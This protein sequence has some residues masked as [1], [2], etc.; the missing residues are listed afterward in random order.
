M[1]DNLPTLE[2]YS[3]GL[4]TKLAMAA[5]LLKS[6]LIPTS[7]KSPE[8]VLVAIL[9]GQEVGLSPLQ[10]LQSVTVIQGR[11][12]LD[13][14]SLKAICIAH[15]MRFETVEWNEKICT[16]RGVRG[17]WKEEFSFTWHDAELMGLSNKENWRRMPKQM[18]YARAVSTL[19]RNMGADIVRGFYSKEEMQDSVPLDVTPKIEKVN[20]KEIQKIAEYTHGYSDEEI[21][22]FTKL[23]DEKTPEVSS[24]IKAAFEADTVY[25]APVAPISES[26]QVWQYRIPLAS[27]K[28]LEYLEG[29]G[30]TPDESEAD[31]YLAPRKLNSKLDKYLEGVVNK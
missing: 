20:K 8:A 15:G 14:A 9:Y 22:T 10:S 3:T 2:L 21:Q 28:Q 11:P 6:N 1:T 17:D 19:A 24:A 27:S 23:V 31:L 4:D 16:L 7:Y 13:A 25:T 12:T 18:L 26:K 5:T 30:C 29:E